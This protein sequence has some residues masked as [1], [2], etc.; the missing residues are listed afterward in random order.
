[1]AFVFHQVDVYQGFKFKKLFLYLFFYKGL[2]KL[3]FSVACFLG[4][5]GVDGQNY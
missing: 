4:L 5:G 2:S 1:M 3:I